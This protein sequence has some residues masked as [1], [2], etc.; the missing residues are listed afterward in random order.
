MSVLPEIRGIDVFGSGVNNAAE[1]AEGSCSDEHIA[2][3]KDI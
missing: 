3:S 2:A 1:K